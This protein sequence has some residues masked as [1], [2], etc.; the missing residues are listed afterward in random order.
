MDATTL[1]EYLNVI[2]VALGVIVGMEIGRAFS[3]WKW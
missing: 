1:G 2:V 3:F